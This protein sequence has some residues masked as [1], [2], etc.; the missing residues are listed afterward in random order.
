MP[1]HCFMTLVQARILAGFVTS[2][3][4]IGFVGLLVA[5]GFM[6]DEAEILGISA[7]AWFFV[8]G[9]VRIALSDILAKRG[10]ARGQRPAGP[11]KPQPW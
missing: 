6:P 3:G 11:P 8:F 9:A 4:V 5:G 7:F 10:R 1:E 2:A